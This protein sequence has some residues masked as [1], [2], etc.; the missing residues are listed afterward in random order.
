[1]VPIAIGRPISSLTVNSGWVLSLGCDGSGSSGS[2]AAHRL[3][4]D[5]TSRS[6]SAVPFGGLSCRTRAT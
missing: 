4:T 3:A 2:T 6:N 5:S 1:M